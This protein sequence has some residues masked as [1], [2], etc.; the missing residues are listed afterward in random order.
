MR[1]STSFHSG[2]E[3]GPF[4][5][6]AAR[7]AELSF[8]RVKINLQKLN[9][10]NSSVD[11]QAFRVSCH[12]TGRNHAKLNS[13]EVNNTVRRKE[14]QEGLCHL[15]NDKWAGIFCHPLDDKPASATGKILAALPVRRR[16]PPLHQKVKT[17]HLRPQED[18]LL[19]RRRRSPPR[20]PNQTPQRNAH[21]RGLRRRKD[22]V[23]MIELII[24]RQ[25]SGRG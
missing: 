2:N 4:F 13:V 23:F 24:T 14:K 5:I 17:L 11:S 9:P 6:K 22:F 21:R 10:E 19:V 3:T 25:P 15:M 7:E 8:S 18:R 20:W 16:Q 12:C 1:A